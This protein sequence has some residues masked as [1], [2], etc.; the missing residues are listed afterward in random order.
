MRLGKPVVDIGAQ[1]VKWHAAFAIPFAARNF[2]AVQ[3]PRAHDLDALSAE[4]HRV[5]HRALHRAPEH[6][7]LL[8]LLRDRIGD[9]L[10]V[11]LG[12]ADLFDIQADVAAHHLAQIGAKRLDVLAFLPDD[13]PR[14]R[15]VDRDARILRGPFDRDL[16][17]RRVRELLL[18][19]FAD[20]DVFGERR[21]V[22]FAVREPLRRPVAC[23]A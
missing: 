8:E 13:D 7:P 19:V 21:P 9:Q 4:A 16:G 6:D 3:T 20:F 5:L 12:L 1:C 10:R 17:D 11:D 22:V 18:Q 15:A 23:D 2:H 14:T